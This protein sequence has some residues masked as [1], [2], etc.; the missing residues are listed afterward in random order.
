[1]AVDVDSVVEIP[2][3][4]IEAQTPAVRDV[5][6]AGTRLT[7]VSSVGQETPLLMPA[8]NS[9]IQGNVQSIDSEA[10]TVRLLGRSEIVTV[11]RSAITS[12]RVRHKHSRAG[13]GALI[14]TGVGVAAG[15]GIV[16]YLA[17]NH[18]EDGDWPGMCTM[19]GVFST[20]GLGAG[21]ALIGAV[22]GAVSPKERWERVD[23]RRL[24]A[25]VM[26]DPRGGVRGRL[27]V[28]F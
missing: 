4:A 24:S 9:R 3:E 27:A 22:A 5:V 6:V 2:A 17:V 18:C 1:V 16:T 19:V 28:R 11:P 26:P 8:L 13:K 10:I 21:G 15:L 12:L 7:E 23:S 14:G 25:A 20:V